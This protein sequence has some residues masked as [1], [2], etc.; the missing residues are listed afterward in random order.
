[1]T[2]L[3]FASLAW[4]TSGYDPTTTD[5]T[6]TGAEVEDAEGT[7]RLWSAIERHVD[8]DR[9]LF[10]KGVYNEVTAWPTQ[11]SWAPYIATC[12][13]T[14][15]PHTSGFLLHVG[16]SAAVASGTPI[17]FV[18][19]VGDNGS[20]GFITMAWHEDLLGR[21]VYAM[22]FAHPH[23]D[24]FEQAE[25]IADAIARIR[26]RTGAAQV[27]VVAHSKGGIAAAIYA[28]NYARAAWPDAAY[29]SVGTRYRDDIR[30]LVFI[31]TPLA[32]ID[33]AFRWPNGNYLSLDADEAFSPASWAAYYPYTT[34]NLYVETDLA[35]QGFSGELFPGQRQ[36]YARQDFELPG[37]SPALGV[38]AAQTDWYTTYEGG[39]GYYSYS[40][41]IDATVDAGGGVLDAIAA[42]GV[43][44]GI[45]LF[46]LA[47]HNPVMPNGTPDYANTLF[48]DTWAELGQMTTNQWADIISAAIGDGLVT[49]GITEEEV[50]GLASGALMLGEISGESDG[51][52]FVDSATATDRL[53]A[54]G[55]VVAEVHLANLSH[56][57]LLYAS[58]ITGELL[59]DAGA[60]DDDDAWMIAFGQRYTKED[61]IG[62]VEDW[63]ADE[64]DTGGDDTGDEDTGVVDTGDTG[65]ADSDS[66]SAAEASE[67]DD[68]ATIGGLPEE[69]GACSGGAGAPVLLGVAVALAAV[70]GRRR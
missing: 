3:F 63:L 32:G 51:L 14:A 68:T 55:A 59:V 57:D 34:A 11:A 15:T 48:G 8:P 7:V 39:W 23:G 16:P 25:L 12:F 61:T 31:A 67:G 50:Q 33:T 47:G 17:L 66:D 65:M 38:Y 62:V 13:G 43:D 22:T 4:A 5:E 29:T 35:E 53:T 42:A 56:L 64:A 26:E 70:V 2:P 1:M 69:C 24:A 9:T 46:V 40:D 10:G 58:P 37:E 19:G 52:V 6:F 45:E 27:D 54:R 41:G 28:S 18:P 36:L 60:A 20:R 30:R 21:P 44:P 49:V